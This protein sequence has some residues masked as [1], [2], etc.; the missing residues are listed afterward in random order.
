MVKEYVYEHVVTSHDATTSGIA[1][2]GSYVE[3][4]CIARERMI[5]NYVDLAGVPS[6]RFLVGETYVHYLSPLFLNDLVEVKVSVVDHNV[7]KGYQKFD[8][9]FIKKESN[10]LIAQGYQVMFFYDF[11]S[12][13]RIPIPRE[14]LKLVGK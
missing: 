10:Q 12:G 6:P 11:D 14:F 2:D 3:W 7:E 13:K 4:A 1:H 5:I 8:Y 9:R